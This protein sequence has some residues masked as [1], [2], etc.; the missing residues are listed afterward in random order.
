MELR[1]YT[2]HDTGNNK[3]TDTDLFNNEF[4]NDEFS[5]DEFSNNGLFD[6]SFGNGLDNNDAL[7]SDIFNNNFDT[8][9]VESYYQVLEL[10]SLAT[11]EEIKSQY[12]QLVRTYHPDRFQDPDAKTAAEERLKT[13]NEAYRVLS[14]RAVEAQ[15]VKYMQREL[16]LVV[17]PSML[18]FGLLEWRQQRKARF[19][20][21]FEKEVEGVDFV[22]S[23]E[24]GWFRVARVSHIYGSHH[25]S[26]E[27]EVEVD[28]TGLATQ[29][30]QGWIDLYLDNT[31]TRIPLTMQVS[32]R[33]WHF[34]ALPRHWLLVGTFI[35]TVLLFTAILA[36]T[37]TH[38]FAQQ[39]VSAADINGG[40]LQRS[41]QSGIESRLTDNPHHLYFS[42]MEREQPTIYMAH[43]QHVASPQRLLVGSQAIG[44][45]AGEFVAYL[46]AETKLPQIYLFN[47]K[48]ERTLQVTDDDTPKA[49]LAWSPMENRF[50][51]LV[52]GGPEGRIGVYDIEQQQEYRLPGE[53]TSGVSHFAWSPDG[54][55]LLFD[56]WRNAERRVYRMVVPDGDLQQLTHFDSW[57]GAWSPDGE[58]IVVAATTGIYRLDS[59]GRQVRRISTAKAQ[60][61]HWSADGTWI[62]Y[63]TEP[64]NSDRPTIAQVD[65][66]D[67]TMSSSV[68]LEQHI[69]W[70]MRPD[71]SDLQQVDVDVLWHQ[72]SPTGATLG[73]VTGNQQ[74]AASLFYLW[75]MESEGTKQLVAEI[76]EPIFTW[77]R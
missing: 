40:V 9:G 38:F 35:F 1:G 52:D 7:N 33:R 23:E 27:F 34:P 25:A 72:W 8:Y 28:S 22:A 31:M 5:N 49:A 70:F 14:S 19:E 68:P 77:S 73:Y 50:A 26:L 2:V 59:S 74:S 65:D 32:S 64:L 55:T 3:H 4:S 62:A 56:L 29:T 54:Q 13:I 58:E 51:Y 45:E 12:K 53:I 69:L 21:R 41:R 10:S 46:D 36:F 57:G 11:Q 66:T 71:G 48:T 18:D 15:L 75:T 17:E 44:E 20:V 37:D 16:G 6:S 24:D 61:P 47:R 42:V 30:Y 63:R 43:S 39:E 67:D 60:R 76:N